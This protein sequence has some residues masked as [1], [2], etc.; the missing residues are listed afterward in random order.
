MPF[1]SFCIPTFQRKNLLVETLESIVSQ[2]EEGV[3]IVV[4]DNGSSDGTIEMMTALQHKFPFII[5]KR[6]E[7]SVTCGENL[8]QVVKQAGGEYCWLMTDDDKLEPGALGKVLDFLKKHPDI[9]GL[10]V[11][12]QGYTKD[13]SQKKNIFY[14][15]SVKEDRLFYSSHEFYSRLGAWVGF[16]S[17]QIVNKKKWEEALMDKR[18]LTFEG[19]HHLFIIAAIVH[20]APYWGFMHQRLVGYRSDNESFS[21]E[22]GK[23]KRF[24]IDLEAYDGVGAAFFSSQ[25]CMQVKSQVLRSLLFWQVIR[26]KVQGLNCSEIAEMFLKSYKKYKGSFFYWTIFVPLLVCPKIILKGVRPFFYLIR[27]F[28]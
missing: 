2:I 16:W 10:S 14:S 3:D 12:V 15:H 19:Y 1:L 8:L 18:Y 24:F 27:R 22:Y 26:A 4:S 11:N 21:Q 25:A 7:S 9:S 5:Y 20:A 6:F 17:A 13:M 23:L 28:L